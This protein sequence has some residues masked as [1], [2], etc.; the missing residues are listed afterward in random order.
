MLCQI[1]SWII[2]IYSFKSPQILAHSTALIDK[3]LYFIGGY[4]SKTDR[5]P[6]FYL[7]LNQ[8]FYISSPA[9]VNLEAPPVNI[10]WAT[11]CVGGANN[12]TI[13]IFGGISWYRKSASYIMDKLI[14]TFDAT[15]REWSAPPIERE[16]IRRRGLQAVIDNKGN[17]Y[18]F[19]GYYEFDNYTEYFK[20]MIIFNTITF[21]YSIGSTINRP[22]SVAGYTA[23][24]L[25][26]GIIVYIGGKVWNGI[27]SIKNITMYD[28]K[29]DSWNYTIAR[30]P[31]D[32]EDRS[33]HSAV[34]TPDGRI[35]CF[36]GIS[37]FHIT[38]SPSLIVLNTTSF[39]WS[40]PEHFGMKPPKLHSHSATLVEN[41]MIIGFGN[42]T[43]ERTSSRI[44][45]L[46]IRNY[47][48][49][50]YY[51]AS[52]PLLLSKTDQLN[53]PLLV[54]AI[55]GI[56]I[57]V[58]SILGLLLFFGIRNYRRASLSYTSGGIEF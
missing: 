13:F 21:T 17:M 1:I 53:P 32:I 5:T 2:S 46:D 37:I 43:T 57:S 14:N 35:I 44:Y 29:E 56:T 23:T 42:V 12:T 26:N 55:V 39:E 47:T 54:G 8:S 11:A 41:H 48:W 4:N 10:I 50:S 15:S 25:P 45:M 49:N 18:M 9:Y 27:V 31:K 52:L 7:D 3:K 24:L 6:F 38:V 40:Y 34:L 30:F 16:P 28:I 20:D 22:P 36:G 19:G 33:Y 58:T 51:E